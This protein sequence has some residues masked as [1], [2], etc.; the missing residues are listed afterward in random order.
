VEDLLH[1]VSFPEGRS[2]KGRAA[3]SVNSLD[4]QTLVQ[5]LTDGAWADQIAELNLDQVFDPGRNLTVEVTEKIGRDIVNFLRP[6]VEAAA[7]SFV[8]LGDLVFEIVR[9]DS[10]SSYDSAKALIGA[11]VSTNAV[12]PKKLIA[13]QLQTRAVF[14]IKAEFSFVLF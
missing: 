2:A 9:A 7:G 6:Q 4:Y 11:V 3:V 13:D 14:C 5:S 10:Q 1:D 8:N 12:D